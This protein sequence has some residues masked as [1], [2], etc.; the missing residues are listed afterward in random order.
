MRVPCDCPPVRRMTSALAILAIAFGGLA[1]LL[2]VTGATGVEVSTLPCSDAR[3]DDTGNDAAALEGTWSLVSYKCE[4]VPSED[5]IYT[6]SPEAFKTGKLILRRNEAGNSDL[7]HRSSEEF[8][9]GGTTVGTWWTLYR[10]YPKYTPKAID[11][12]NTNPTYG[13]EL[14]YP[15][16]YELKGDTLRICRSLKWNGPRPSQFRAPKGSSRVLA[17]WTRVKRGS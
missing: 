12:V 4:G 1:S 5:P 16:I 11:F 6:P 7:D 9:E 14:A 2:P 17:V 13:L 15:G 3:A 10:V 8:R